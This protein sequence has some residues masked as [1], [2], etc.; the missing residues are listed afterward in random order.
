MSQIRKLIGLFGI[1]VV[2]YILCYS[3]FISLAAIGS[4]ISLSAH[5]YAAAF[6]MLLLM[7]NLSPLAQSCFRYKDREFIDII[8]Y[9]R[10]SK[11]KNESSRFEPI[12][13]A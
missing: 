6:V 12:I 5:Y 11:V 1:L 13:M 4:F 7:R 9:Y 2:N 3:P 8:V 10:V